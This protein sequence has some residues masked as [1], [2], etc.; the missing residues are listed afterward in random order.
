MTSRILY[1]VAAVLLLLFAILHTIGFL[2]IDPQWGVDGLIRQVRQTTFL[3]QGQTRSYWDFFV[4]FGFTVTVWQ[5]FAG[6]VA[7][8][9]GGLPG[10]TLASLPLIRWGIVAAMAAT[11]WLSWVYFFPAPLLFSVII[12]LC[13]GLAAWR[14]R[15]ATS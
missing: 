3:V 15:P 5:L 13:L 6:L 10:E 12:T 7:W 8:Q 9:L 4:G 11:G 2:V 14:G 1:R